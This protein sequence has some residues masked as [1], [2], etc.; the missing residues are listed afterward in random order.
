VQTYEAGGQY[1]GLKLDGLLPGVTIKTS[2]T[3]FAPIE[4]LQ[5]QKLQG[6]TW[7]RFGDINQRRGRR[8]MVD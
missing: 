1:R 2:A 3:D 5:L 7:H 6:E 4:Q 8:L